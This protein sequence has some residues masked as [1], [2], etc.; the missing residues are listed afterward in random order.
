[1]PSAW[2]FIPCAALALAAIFWAMEPMEHGFTVLAFLRT[3][4][5]LSVP[6]TLISLPFALAERAHWRAGAGGPRP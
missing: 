1:M 2:V 3:A 5:R 6:V 4:L